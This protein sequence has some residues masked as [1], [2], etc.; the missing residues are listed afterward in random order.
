VICGGETGIEA[1]E[2]K[3]IWALDLMDQCRFSDIPFF[4]KQLGTHAA[5]SAGKRGKMDDPSEWP[6]ELRVREFPEALR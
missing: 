4:M 2:F 5:R 1:R 3:T 6:D